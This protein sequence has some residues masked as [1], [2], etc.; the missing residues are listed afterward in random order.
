M[1][2]EQRKIYLM[3]LLSSVL[4]V[5]M[6]MIVSPTYVQAE[7]IRILDGDKAIRWLQKNHY[8]ENQHTYIDG[9]KSYWTKDNFQ[10]FMNLLYSSPPSMDGLKSVNYYSNF[11]RDRYPKAINRIVIIVDWQAYQDYINHKN[12]ILTPHPP[13]IPVSN[14]CG[15]Y[16]A[17]NDEQAWFSRQMKAWKDKKLYH[18]GLKLYP[19]GRGLRGFMNKNQYEVNK[20]I[21]KNRVNC[22]TDCVNNAAWPPRSTAESQAYS[23]CETS[24]YTRSINGGDLAYIKCP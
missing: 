20:R 17:M 19:Q 21:W 22:Y 3:G 24:C 15:K 8:I 13:P 5:L 4:T 23:R 7:D 2:L 11:N 9:Y 6:L 18:Q 1:K 16:V 12:L 10:I 14:P